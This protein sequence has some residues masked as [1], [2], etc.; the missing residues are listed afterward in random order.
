MAARAVWTGV[1]KVAE[2]VCP[3]KMYTDGAVMAYAQ[4]AK[5]QPAAQIAISRVLFTAPARLGQPRCQS[6]LVASRGPI[7]TL[8]YKVEIERKLHLANYQDWLL[9]FS[10]AQQV[11][12]ID[13]SF[14]GKA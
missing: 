13:L 3:V 4:H 5:T 9:T 2:I 7:N 1:I 10:Y 8:Q 14:D 6:N 12:T 11:T